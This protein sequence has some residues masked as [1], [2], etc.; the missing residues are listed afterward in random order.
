MS[1][2]ARRGTRFRLGAAFAS[3]PAAARDPGR[4]VRAD[5]PGSVPR[6]SPHPRWVRA[7]ATSAR[8][9]GAPRRS[10][11]DGW[12]ATVTERD[13]ERALRRVNR[14]ILGGI[15]EMPKASRC[16]ERNWNWEEATRESLS[17]ASQETRERRGTLIF[18]H[19]F[20]DEAEHWKELAELLVRGVPGGC[21]LIL[22]R[23]PSHPFLVGDEERDVTAW[24]EPRLRQ[25]LAPDESR[26][27]W[28]CGG[29]EP[30]VRWISMLIAEQEARGA[31]P[32][33]VLLA[34]FSQG[35]GLAMAVATAETAWTPAL[36]GVLCLRG[37]LPVRANHAEASTAREPSQHPERVTVP[38]DVRR[39]PP[40]ALLCHGGRDI[41][42]P[43][44]WA[45]YA[46]RALRARRKEKGAGR[47]ESR[48]E[49]LV[50]EDR[51]H[52]LGADEVWRARW[53][54]RSRLER[55]LG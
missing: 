17:I 8:D 38:A 49:V 45:Q 51:G 9:A 36:G 5:P 12:A 30:A 1:S 37:Y 13:V 3:S 34:G 35:A 52:D 2:L 10:S 4:I 32:G 50:S 44:E 41:V 47:N 31:T 39:A 21:D 23:A 16:L 42:A 20:S 11:W 53:W 28:N 19:G 18:L 48:V 33:S 15:V 54:L 55:A 24:F 14:R 46:A 6:E 29:I 27:S 25:T 40:P 22:P 43:R 26:T 7:A